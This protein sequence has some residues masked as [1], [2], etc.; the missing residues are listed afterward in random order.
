MSWNVVCQPGHVA[1]ESTAAATDG[2]RDRQETGGRRNHIIPGE[3]V[4]HDLQ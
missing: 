1:E 3:F 2:I 4:P